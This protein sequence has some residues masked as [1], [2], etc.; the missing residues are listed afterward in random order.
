MYISIDFLSTT[1]L[2]TTFIE[3][4]DIVSPKNFF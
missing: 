3:A 4:N 2:I 1:K